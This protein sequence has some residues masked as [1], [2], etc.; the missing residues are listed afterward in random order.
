MFTIISQALQSV[1]RPLTNALSSIFTRPTIDEQAFKDFERILIEA[2]TGLTTARAL[3]AQLKKQTHTALT[4]SELKHQFRQELLNLTRKHSY[5]TN[6]SIYL[7]VG[8]NG[9]GKTTTS[10]KLAYRFM[11]SGKKVLLVAADT[12]R[13]AAVEQLAA[14]ATQYDIA[15]AKGTAGQDSAAVVFKA[16]QT[17]VNEHYD[18]LIIDTAGRLHTNINLMAE[19]A[20]IRRVIN[21]Q[22][23]NHFVQT[24]LTLDALLGQSSLEQARIFNQS[25]L[26]DGIVLTK[27]DSSSKGGIVYALCHELNTPLAYMC[28]GERIEDIASFEPE[29]FVNN[30]LNN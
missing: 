27:L 23:P 9:S 11:Q 14:W 18:I 19:L 15:I 25:V 7:M 3:I 20:K 24:L 8:I 21:R 17:Y 4:G 29:F 10:A 5:N 12:F 28:A 16:L 30:T 26:V 13:A 22:L 2:D 1:F 6:A